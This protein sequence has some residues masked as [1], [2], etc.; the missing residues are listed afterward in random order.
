[1]ILKRL[2]KE[3]LYLKGDFQKETSIFYFNDDDITKGKS[4]MFGPKGTPYEYIPMEYDIQI[5]N[6]YPFTPPVVL[7]KTNDGNTRFH[8]NFYIDGKVCLSIL[9]TYSGPKWASSMN[10]STV[11]VSIYSLLTPNPLIH[12]PAYENTS[13]TNPKNSQYSQYIEHQLIKLFIQSMEH[14]YYK[15]F[16]DEDEIFKNE[17]LR[18]YELLKIKIAEK[19]KTPETIYTLLPYSMQGQTCWRKLAEKIKN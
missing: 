9:G 10:I 12:E 11:L 18:N 2:G 16:M 5:K 1:M 6:D 13:I 15:K 8:P 7:Y 3:L 17:I 19:A 4:I 14:N